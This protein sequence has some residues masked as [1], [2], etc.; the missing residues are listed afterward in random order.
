M[1]IS[2]YRMIP[3]SAGESVFVNTVPLMNII[4]HEIEE[5]VIRNG[6]KVDFY[7]GFQRYSFFTRQIKRYQ[8]L[9][10]VCRRVH[11]WGIPDVTPP[12]IPGVEYH[13]LTPTQALAREW[14]LIVDTPQFFTALLTEEQTYGQE[15]PKGAR[16]FQGIWTYDQDLVGKGYLLLSQ[17]L[18]Q[19]YSPVQQ[20][21]YAEQNRVLVQISNRLVQ[22]HDRQIS[23]N[24]FDQHRDS[25]LQ[26]GLLRCESPLLLINRAQ[27]VQAATPVAAALLQTDLAAVVGQHISQIREGLLSGIVMLA[28]Q[29]GVTTI[30]GAFGPIYVVSSPIP[31]AT[32]E[33]LGWVI[34]LQHEQSAEQGKANE[35]AVAVPAL[36]RN[37]S[38]LQQIMAMLPNAVGH[39]E[40]QKRMLGHMQRLIGEMDTQI[41]RL[42][43]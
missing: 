42:A 26:A 6:L 20:R 3:K 10:R 7:A 25:I 32:G 17:V 24:L 31:A 37:L 12:S 9:A 4:S 27:E 5:A 29:Q 1:D 8:R 36:R 2:L 11:V 19:G 13:P 23:Q 39:P 43:A 34:E 41:D 38:G 18:G 33:P 14:F 16:T 15:V 22:R 40:V 35:L 28:D 30:P 21:D